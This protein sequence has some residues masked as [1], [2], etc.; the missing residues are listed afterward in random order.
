MRDLAAAC[1]CVYVSQPASSNAP[2]VRIHNHTR[3]C[4]NLVDVLRREVYDPITSWPTPIDRWTRGTTGK[5]Q[6]QHSVVSVN[7]CKVQPWSAV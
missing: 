7:A 1:V 2:F 5:Q 6:T 4:T 3:R